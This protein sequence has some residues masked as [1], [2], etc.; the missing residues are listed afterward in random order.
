MMTSTVYNNSTYVYWPDYIWMAN[1]SYGG[2]LYNGCR[3]E[4]CGSVTIRS[5]L[6]YDNYV[7][8]AD[9][10]TVGIGWGPIF[11]SYGYGGAIYNACGGLTCGLVTVFNSHLVNNQ[12]EGGM[13]GFAQPVPHDPTILF[14]P[15]GNAYGAAIF[16]EG[17]LVAIRY[18]T[19]SENSA[20]GGLTYGDGIPGVGTG[21]G[22]Y[23]LLTDTMT[24]KGTIVAGNAADTGLDCYG[25]LLSQG[26]NLLQSPAGCTLSG[27]TTGNVLG[28]NPMLWPLGDNGGP[29]W[30]QAMLFPSPAVD[31][32]DPLDC[33]AT[34]QRGAP[35]PVDGDNDGTAV[36]D[37]GAYEASPPVGLMLPAGRLAKL[38]MKLTQHHTPTSLLITRHFHF[39]MAD[40]VQQSQVRSCLV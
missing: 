12:V 25:A 15:G 23:Q 6:F 29:T 3:S 9:G 18:S 10:G 19:I 26:Y 31:G 5:S 35:R 34:D 37:I 14:G 22:I 21:G 7:R 38:S 33:P 39:Q 13:G 8:G 28:Q 40:V 24:L 16:S 32:G 30:T 36:C 20:V 1:H 4:G 27:D 11:G 17:G 2:G